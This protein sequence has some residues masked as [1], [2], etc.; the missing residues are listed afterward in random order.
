MKVEGERQSVQDVKDVSSVR[1][2][3]GD[4]ITPANDVCYKPNNLI[5]LPSRFA[6]KAGDTLT[7]RHVS[8]CDVTRAVGM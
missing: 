6:S 5:S 3:Q 8:S 1:S 4:D 2:T 7:S